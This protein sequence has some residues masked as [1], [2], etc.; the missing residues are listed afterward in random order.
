MAR[1]TRYNAKE[2]SVIVD[3]TYITGLGE[4]MISWSKDEAFFE[5]VVGAQGDVVKS[6]INNDIH[7]LTIAVQPTSPQF[8]FLLEL[9]KRKESFPV[10]VINK[11][12]GI[13][14]GG[15]QAN[16]MEAPEIALSSSAEDLEFTI[17]VFDGV[18]EV[19]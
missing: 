9:A 6:E 19:A 4:S 17:C 1:V 12:L 7:S 5:P 2:C 8:S 18:T 13:R 3:G 14:L 10:W 15:T 16:I 11:S